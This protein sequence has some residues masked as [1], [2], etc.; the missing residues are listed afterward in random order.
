MRTTG[1]PRFDELIAVAM[2]ARLSEVHTNIPGIVEAFD[3]GKGTVDVQPAVNRVEERLNGSR[4]SKPFPVI[5][6]VPIAYPA[7]GGYVIR[8]PL[9]PGDMVELRFSEKDTALFRSTGQR[10][11]PQFL[12]KHD[13]SYPTAWPCEIRLSQAQ[14]SPAEIADAMQIDGPSGLVVGK[15]LTAQPVAMAPAVDTLI[16]D[17][18]NAIN[19]WVPISMDGGAALKAA[20]A[21]WLTGPTD[22]AASNLKAEP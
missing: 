17:L 21:V 22:T 8:W 19:A 7:G 6:N 10:S 16:A 2:E 18:K 20:L 5:R 12:R 4:I 11:D 1:D 13:I 9:V 14:A 3:A 15:P